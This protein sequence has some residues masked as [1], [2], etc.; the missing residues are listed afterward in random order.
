MNN[1]CNRYVNRVKVDSIYLAA[2]KIETWHVSTNY[3]ILTGP[4]PGVPYNL[5]ITDHSD[6]FSIG[7]MWMPPIDA[8][9]V[10]VAYY[11]IQ[12]KF[13]SE[14]WKTLSKEKILPPTTS[15]VCQLFKKM[16]SCTALSNFSSLI[17]D[18]QMR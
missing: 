5:T 16:L 18:T 3:Y 8:D 12:Y 14:A 1:E 10:A 17:T 4:K 7:I 13:E 11:Q 2:S 6:A 15:Y 9:R